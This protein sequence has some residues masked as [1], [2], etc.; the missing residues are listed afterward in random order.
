VA[1][2][3]PARGFLFEH[4]TEINYKPIEGFGTNAS[5]EVIFQNQNILAFLK[6][7]YPK[8]VISKIATLLRHIV[9][10]SG[11]PGCLNLGMWHLIAE[12]V[13][14]ASAYLLTCLPT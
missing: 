8:K 9:G 10:V 4:A 7:I 1:Q 11:V 2:K 14:F 12:R 3:R 5:F 13:C 6:A